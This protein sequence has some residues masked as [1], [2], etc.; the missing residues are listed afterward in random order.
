M[1]QLFLMDP[2]EGVA[3]ATDTTFALMRAAAARG[4]RIFFARAETL[5]LWGGTAHVSAREVLLPPE[6]HPGPHFEWRGEAE[7]RQVEDFPVVWIRTDPPFDEAYLEATWILDRVDRRRTLLMNDPTGIRGANEKLYALN[8]SELCPPTL[9]TS[10]RAHL[11]RFVE[12]HG[13]AV[14]K[15]LAGYAGGGILFANAKMRGLSALI[16]VAT[17]GGA[18]TEAQ[19]YLPEAAR[20]DKRIIL[21]N[22]EPLGAVLRVHGEGEERNNLHL[23]GSAQKTTL[24]D[25]D[26]RIIRAIAP[27]LREDGLRFVGVDVIGGKLTE[28]NVTSPTGILEIEALDGPGAR[29]RVIQWTEENAPV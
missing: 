17:P 22:G 19:A 6:G 18:R 5:S 24:D 12:E 16:E 1:Q 25:D 7:V 4:H 29:S 20:G 3:P 27:R 10:D 14:L 21:L 13:E 2:L 26:R 23:G 28:I 8:F 15:P 11:R 9:V